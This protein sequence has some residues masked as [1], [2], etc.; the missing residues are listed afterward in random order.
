MDCVEEDLKSASVTQFWKTSGR[1]RTTLYD[2]AEDRQQLELVAPF[3]AKSSWTVK[4]CWL[5]RCQVVLFKYISTMQY[6]SKVPRICCL[7]R[8]LHMHLVRT[9]NNTYYQQQT[10]PLQPASFR[11]FDITR[12]GY[13]RTLNVKCKPI[14][15]VAAA[16][17]STGQM[18][19]LLPN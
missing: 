8:S 19:L 9:N 17:F 10:L 13:V 5:F 4:T 18:P 14:A 6:L 1:T 15:I 7:N 12:A 11:Q 2:I 16:S 3:M